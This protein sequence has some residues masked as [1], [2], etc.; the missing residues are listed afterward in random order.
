MG[1]YNKRDLEFDLDCLDRLEQETNAKMLTSPGLAMNAK[2]LGQLFD[3]ERRR[4]RMR[5]LNSGSLIGDLRA[6]EK[7]FDRVPSESNKER[8]ER[9]FKRVIRAAGANN[10]R[11]KTTGLAERKPAEPGAETDEHGCSSL[12][13][14]FFA[15]VRPRPDPL[16]GCT[17]APRWPYEGCEHDYPESDRNGQTR[18]YLAWL[19]WKFEKGEITRKEY[20]DARYQHSVA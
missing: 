16:L 2:L 18:G 8:R 20:D 1:L 13:R 11:H 12:E 7:E 5:L 15:D 10:Q 6:A 9:M 14:A 4:C 19:H 17:I 3:K